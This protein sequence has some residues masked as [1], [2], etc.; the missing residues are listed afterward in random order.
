MVLDE[1]LYP[2]LYEPDAGYP[3]HQALRQVLTKHWQ[4]HHH[5]IALLEYGIQQ[6]P[7]YLPSALK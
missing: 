5:F 4:Q 2:L 6:L 7:K 3:E 1:S